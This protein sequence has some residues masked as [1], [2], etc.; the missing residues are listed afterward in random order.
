MH[1][2]LDIYKSSTLNRDGYGRYTFLFAGWGNGESSEC[3]SD[4]DDI[5]EA[6]SREPFLFAV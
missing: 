1:F 3:F 2:F 4:D 5:E 6:Y